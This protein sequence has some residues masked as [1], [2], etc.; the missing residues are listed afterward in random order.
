MEQF[1]HSIVQVRPLSLLLNFR[2]RRTHIA[3]RNE[4]EILLYV[5][6]WHIFMFSSILHANQP[7]D[8][9]S[10]WRIQVFLLH[11]TEQLVDDDMIVQGHFMLDLMPNFDCFWCKFFV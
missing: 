3:L 4:I 11:I 2:A 10:E 7:S 1:K 9:T 8:V 6:A 5:R